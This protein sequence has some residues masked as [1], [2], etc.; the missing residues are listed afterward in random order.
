MHDRAVRSE[1]GNTRAHAAVRRLVETLVR[2][3]FPVLRLSAGERADGD[4]PIL[5]VPNHNNGLL[6][7]VVLRLATGRHVRFLA[8]STL[9][10][11]PLGKLAMD[12]FGAIP[13]YRSRDVSSGDVS[14]GDDGRVAGNERT[15][16]LCRAAIA[17][18]EP[19]ALF[20]EGTSHSEPQLKPFKTGAARIALSAE[21]EHDFQLGLR[22]VPAAI[23]Y[24]AKTIFRSSALIALGTP[25]VVRDYRDAYMQ[26]AHE[27]A[28]MLT[29]A[30]RVSLEAEAL[31]ADTR[32]LLEGVAEV[33]AYA[34]GT[35]QQ[36]HDVASRHAQAKAMLRAYATLSARDPAAA[37][38]IVQ[39]ATTYVTTLRALGI[40][41]PWEMEVG[42]VHTGAALRELAMLTLLAPVALVG[43]LLSWVPYRVTGVL[44]KRAEEDVQGTVKLVLGMLLLPA[45]WAFAALVAAFWS[46]WAGL[47]IWVLAA[48]TGYAALRFEERVYRARAAL[49]YAWLRRDRPGVARDLVERRRALARRVEAALRAAGE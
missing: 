20:P 14:S 34:A 3:F 11:N 38:E 13:V 12:A 46:W 4:G 28:R 5:F 25:I 17:R 2:L 39:E 35:A 43:A 26:D 24:G 29:A 27:A 1:P 31:T 33:S 9:F 22:V 19:L 7:P 10:E 32:E 21:A 15:F 8:K 45:W 37:A 30:M 47:A 49:G 6:D 16:A 48:P 42:R 36:A 41:D 40:A 44:A 18:S 23:V